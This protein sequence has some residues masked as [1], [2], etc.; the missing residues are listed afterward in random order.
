[1]QILWILF[2]EYDKDFN[3]LCTILNSFIE[4]NNLNI[5]MKYALQI[6]YS[7]EIRYSTR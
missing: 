4:K 7:L 2:Q 5:I 6:M 1:M 3:Y